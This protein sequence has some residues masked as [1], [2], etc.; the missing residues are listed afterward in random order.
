MLNKKLWLGLATLV[1]VQIVMSNLAD[2]IGADD[3]S[4]ITLRSVLI[5]FIAAFAGG[6]VAR[7][8]FVLPALGVWLAIWAAT[9]YVLYQIA[10]PFGQDPFASILQHNW[11]AFLLSGAATTVGAFLGQVLVVRLTRRSA[12]A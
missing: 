6:T 12:A 3:L 11:V 2:S 8:G 9:T 4:Y 7:R 5:A 10:E 1:A